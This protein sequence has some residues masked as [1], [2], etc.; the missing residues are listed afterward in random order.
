MRRT[1]AIAREAVAFLDERFEAARNEYDTPLAE[2]PGVAEMITELD[3]CE[4]RTGVLQPAS[5][6]GEKRR[7]NEEWR[8]VRTALARPVDEVDPT[9][10]CAMVGYPDICNDLF[11]VAC[12]RGLSESTQVIG[13]GDGGNGLMEAMDAN[14]P[15]FRYILDRPHLKSH[16]FDTA[17]ALGIEKELRPRWVQ[18]W[19]D[20]LHKGDSDGVLRDL[21]KLQREA[22]CDRLRRFIDYLDRFADAVSYDEYEQAGWPQG[23]G[24]VEAAHRIVPQPR[25]KIVGACWHPDSVNRMLALR[26][27]RANDWWEDFWDWMGAKK[28]AA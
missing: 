6:P 25:L 28:G 15:N 11:A 27:V 3:G 23:S 8:E 17:E 20:R 2:R 21:R 1:H 19:M 13:V 12:L 7:R 22:G 10:V 16:F 4:I 26:V 18:T 14:L 5:A 24:E 9:Y